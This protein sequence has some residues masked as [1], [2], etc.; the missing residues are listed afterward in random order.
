MKKI[1]LLTC[2]AVPELVDFKN[3]YDDRPLID[4]LRYDGVVAEPAIWSDAN[5]Y[6]EQYDAV[7]IRSPWDYMYRFADFSA[8]LQQLSIPIFNSPDVVRYNIHKFYLRDF[9]QQGIPIVPTVFIDKNTVCS[10]AQI[11]EKKEWS[12][13]IVKPAISGGAYHTY[14]IAAHEVGNYQPLIDGLLLEHDLLVQSFLPEIMEKGEYSLIFFN[15]QYSHT[16]QKIAQKG[17]FRVQPKFGGSIK[18]AEPS[19]TLLSV[20]QN[21]IDQQGD[22]LYAR[23]DIVET[24]QTPLLM[25]LELIEPHLFTFEKRE[26]NLFA[27]AIIDKVYGQ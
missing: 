27:Q 26:Q 2:E 15:Q 8:W 14:R 6:W 23:V 16:V 17:D 25:E 18:N 11:A 4:L 9:E 1:A 12:E 24:E 7:I 19:E 10:L 21:I 22:L 3:A 20:A 13:L 5:I